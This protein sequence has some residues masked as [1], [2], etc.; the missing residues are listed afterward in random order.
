MVGQR[1]DEELLKAQAGE[2]PDAVFY[3]TG[4]AAMVADMDAALR[5]LGVR[6]RHIRQ[7]KQSLPIDRAAARRMR[8]RA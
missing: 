1:I 6:G 3:L 2:L 4:P 8:P 5:R 7:S